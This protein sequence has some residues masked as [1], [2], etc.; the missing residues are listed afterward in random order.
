MVKRKLTD[1]EILSLPKLYESGLSSWVIAKKFDTHHSN[2]LHHLKKLNSKRRDHSSAAKEGVKEGRILIKKN[3]IPV[4]L[5][6]NEDLASSIYKLNKIETI[7][8]RNL[9]AIRLK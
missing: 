3:K 6:L 1:K 9:E 8:P 4:N 5:N 2:I 7:V